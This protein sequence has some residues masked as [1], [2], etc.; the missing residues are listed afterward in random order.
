MSNEELRVYHIRR[1]YKNKSPRTI[2]NHT[3]LAEARKHCQSP[4]TKGKDWFDGFDYMPCCA[5]KGDKDV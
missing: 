3:T 2:R 1:F 5:P 4:N